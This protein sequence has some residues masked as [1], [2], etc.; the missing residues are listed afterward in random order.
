MIAVPLGAGVWWAQ[1]EWVD[2]KVG[3]IKALHDREAAAA[4]AG[5]GK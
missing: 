1:Y 2:A 4:A 3:E 5:S